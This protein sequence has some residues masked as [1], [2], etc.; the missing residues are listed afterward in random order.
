MLCIEPL[1]GIANNTDWLESEDFCRM[2]AAKAPCVS[3]VIP[4][5]R[6]HRTI[7][8]S[9]YAMTR[10]DYDLSKIEI[11]VVDDGSPDEDKPNLDPFQ[12]SLDIKYLYLQDEG[13]RVSAVRNLGVACAKYDYIL[14]V[15]CDIVVSP[16]FMTAHINILRQSKNVISIGLRDSYDTPIGIEPIEFSKHSTKDLNVPKLKR[17]WRL[18]KLEKS[19]D[20]PTSN[21]AW[22]LCSGGNMGFHK[23]LFKKIGRF[24]ERFVFWGGE[25]NEWAYRA[26][27]KGAYFHI[28]SEVLSQHFE[29][30]ESEF[31]VQRNSRLVERNA[32]L[33]NLVPVFEKSEKECGEIPYVSIFVTHY[34]KLGYLEE[35]LASI[36]R[37]TDY[38]FEVVL[39]N[40]SDCDVET[41]IN[42]LPNNLSS[43]IRLFNNS[44]HLGVEL[45]FKKAISLCRGEFIAQLDADDYLLPKAIDRLIHKLNRCDADIAYSKYKLLKD[46]MLT[47]GWSCKDST[48]EMRLLGGMYYTPLRV[49]RSRAIARVG[50]MRVLGLKG[51]V[52]FSLYSQME[53]AC[54][55]IF[56]DEFTYVYR[57]VESSITNTAFASQIEG[58]Y[59]VVEAN[60]NELSSTKDYKITK[61][62]ERLYTVDFSEKDT[63]CYRKHLS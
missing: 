12:S 55:S 38:R 60:A 39:V 36:Q 35:C 62:K 29:C 10:L 11:L 2:W 43:K 33:R 34:K 54:K 6:R 50:G 15:D 21:A 4:Y 14:I 45:S 7:L 25:D 42:R 27:K 30:H 51:A 40:D 20:N 52:D 56:C 8:Q 37:S 44:E 47:D 58:T 61:V 31:Q 3:V 5:Y 57:Q 22:R 46:E 59:K 18:A 32:L 23:S 53:L 9:L 1:Q 28:Q 19:T 48:R 41:A 13:Y 16:K 26:Y 49:F 17:D 24:N 63:V